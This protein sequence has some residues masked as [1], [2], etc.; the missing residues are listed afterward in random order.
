MLQVDRRW[1]NEITEQNSISGAANFTM[2]APGVKNG[3][4]C[5]LDSTNRID[6]P[7]AGIDLFTHCVTMHLCTLAMQALNNLHV[8]KHLHTL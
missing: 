5:N 6:S 3:W 4:P 2:P 8:T 1:Q 7:N